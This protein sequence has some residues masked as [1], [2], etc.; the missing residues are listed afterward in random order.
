LALTPIDQTGSRQISEL[1]V[2]SG[3]GRNAWLTIVRDC[4]HVEVEGG[5]YESEA[6]VQS[7]SHDLDL[8]R[9]LI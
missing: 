5:G 7:K 9:Y 1:V 3:L 6:V 4:Y 2:F 8:I